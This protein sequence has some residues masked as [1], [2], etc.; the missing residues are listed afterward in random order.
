VTKRYHHPNPLLARFD[1]AR[2]RRELAALT[3]LLRA[4]VAVP[5]PLAVARTAAGWELAL[6]AVPGAQSVREL[7][8]ARAQPPRGWPHLAARLAALLA[9]LESAG[10]EHGDLHP[11]NVLVDEAG[12]PWLIDLAHARRARPDAARALAEVVECAAVA[13]E[14][15]PVRT[16]LRFLAAWLRALPRELRPELAGAALARAIERRARARRQELV[17]LGLGRWLRESSRVRASAREIG[18][19]RVRVF[20]RRDLDEPRAERLL[21]ALLAPRAPARLDGALVLG[22]DAAELRARWLGAARLHEHGLAV[23][24]PA[25]L[26]LWPRWSASA[27]RAAFEPP[28]EAER[29]PTCAALEAA[30]AERGLALVSPAGALVADA[31]GC[32]ALPPREPEDVLDLRDVDD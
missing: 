32:Y 16:R 24:R 12:E 11:G 8:D 17:R 18:G 6:A 10:W 30:F 19:V 5:R 3:E 23:A 9:Q 1:G 29:A 13:R 26:A 7:F 25:V 31:A 27:A 21:A 14:H 20:V 2:A 4:G 15:L 22:A 28:P